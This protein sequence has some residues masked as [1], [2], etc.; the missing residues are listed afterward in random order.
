VDPELVLLVA[1]LA[2][3][4]LVVWP[5]ALPAA[6]GGRRRLDPARVAWW[7]LVLPPFAGLLVFAFLVGWV[8]QEPNPAD[9]R[10]GSFVLALAWVGAA[11]VLRASARALWSIHASTRTSI[12]IGTVGLLVPRVVVSEAFRRRVSRPALAAALAHE[13]AHARAKDPLRIWCARIAADLQWP[14]PGTHRR[15]ASWLLALEAE[16]DDEAIASGISGE[17]LAEAIL[18]AARFCAA[19]RLPSALAG[20]G[21]DGIAWRVRRLISGTTRGRDERREHRWLV[22]AACLGLLAAA[23]WLGW[24]HGDALLGALLREKPW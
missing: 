14:V 6:W 18:A 21:G 10:I 1:T 17:D 15:F 11:G 5:T 23:A 13:R 8:I 7:R 20:G 9:E 16:R 12:P 4:G 22:P 24:H 2:T 3:L 19:P